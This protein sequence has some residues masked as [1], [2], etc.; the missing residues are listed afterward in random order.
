MKVRDILASYPLTGVAY[1]EFTDTV[2]TASG[3]PILCSKTYTALITG[4]A[5][6]TTFSLD[7]ATSKFQIYSDSFNQIGTY[8]VTLTGT[9]TAEPTKFAT[10]TFSIIIVNPCLTKT[11]IS[12]VPASVEN[13]VAFAGFTT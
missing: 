12:I 3:N 5:T 1:T 6:L 9:V 4:P 10:T 8:T 7:V 13:L 11:V 2:S